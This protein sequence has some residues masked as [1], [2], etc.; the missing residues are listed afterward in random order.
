LQFWPFSDTELQ[1]QSRSAVLDLGFWWGIIIGGGLI[2]ARLLLA[3]VLRDTAKRIAFTLWGI[4]LFHNATKWLPWLQHPTWSGNWEITWKVE[5]DN[6]HE[7]NVDRAQMYR[8]FNR[9]AAVS[10]Y[11]T[12][13]G[14]SIPYKFVGEL[15][16][17]MT[18]V[19]G[20]WSD[21]RGGAG[22]YHGSFQMRVTGTA[23]SAKGLWI[24]FSETTNEI[25][26]GDLI[27]N[28]TTG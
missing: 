16:R 15:S 20:T 5:S 18:I 25:K 7:S 27:W 14:N 12:L 23:V 11:S 9:I 4:K 2:A 6:F 26:A 21:N 13:E 22:G 24:G 10:S 3:A 19:T 17:D 8:A 28:K 1:L